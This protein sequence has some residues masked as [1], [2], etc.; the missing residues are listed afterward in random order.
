MSAPETIALAAHDGHLYAPVTIAGHA[1]QFL[2][3]TGA[4]SILVDR[5]V[6]TQLGLASSG[7]FEASGAAR[8]GGLQLAKIPELRVGA[9]GRLTNVVVTTLDLAASSAGTFRADGILGYPF[10]ASSE[11]RIDFAARTMTFAPPGSFPNSGEALSLDVDRGLPEVPLWVNGMLRAPFV[12]DTGNAAQLLIYSPFERRH[13]GLVPFSAVRHNSYGIGGATPSYRSVLDRL[14]FGSIS[15][16]HVDTDVMLAT[17]GAFADRFDA[18][19]VGLGV[20]Q[21]FV[22][23]FDEARATLYV[24]RGSAF[25]DGHAR[26]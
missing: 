25:D 16:Y 21:N 15:L 2:V 9:H 8:T 23:T 6:A 5:A 26:N 3:D 14:D 19:N 20:L 18:G 24:E 12:I 1:Y 7:A 22:I 11:V 13:R 4:Q 10:F 17:R